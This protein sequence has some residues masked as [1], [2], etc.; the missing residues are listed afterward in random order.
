MTEYGSGY[1]ILA[2][3]CNEQRLS[4]FAAIGLHNSLAKWFHM[5]NKTLKL[6]FFMSKVALTVEVDHNR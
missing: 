5:C 6:L 2:V 3:D 1:L 4:N